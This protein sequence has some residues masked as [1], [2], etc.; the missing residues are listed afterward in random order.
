MDWVAELEE[1]GHTAITQ[2][3]S[4]VTDEASDF[5]EAPE[6]CAALAAAEVVA[7]LRGKSSA[8]LPE[9]VQAWLPGR[10]APDAAL[11]AKAKAA[12]E[13]VVSDSELKDLWEEASDFA[14]WLSTV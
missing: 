11:V 8:S 1:S 3:L 12:T 9:T 5:I 14:T 2:A 6:C 10:P 4:S 13:A 7:G